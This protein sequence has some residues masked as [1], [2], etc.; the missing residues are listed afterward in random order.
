M[1]TE[2]EKAK[3]LIADDEKVN[4][5]VLDG[6]LKPYYKTVIAKDGFQVFKRLEKSP[7]PDLILLDVVMPGMDGFEVCRKV[8]D[9]PLT[10]E[11]PVIFITG[12]TDEQHEALG[13]EVGAVDYIQKPFSPMITLARVKTQV[14]LKRRGDRL[15]KMAIFDGLTGI[16]NRRRFDEFLEYEWERSL[17]YRHPLSLILMDI[18][19]FKRYNDYFGHSEGDE[20][21]KKVARAIAE[22]LPRTADLACRYGGEEFA[23]ILPETNAEGATIAARRILANCRDLRLPH[24]Q[25]E[26]ENIVT[27]SLG[28]ATMTPTNEIQRQ[29]IIEMADKGLY[30]AKKNGR[31][32][33]RAFE[34]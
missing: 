1:E 26:T 34:E 33:I 3:I 23:C 14:E 16:P 5:D 25:S 15:E 11:I 2:S 17:R 28:T 20:C 9:N 24:P 6:L 32:Q 12:Q 13:F 30:L 8:K 4:I 27:L 22:S 18:D 7:L 31:N 21:L 19:F 10:R 29:T